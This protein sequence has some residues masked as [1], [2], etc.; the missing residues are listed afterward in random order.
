MLN[1]KMDASLKQ[2]QLAGRL[3]PPLKCK[4]W[5]GVAKKVRERL[6]I[7]E[8]KSEISTLYYL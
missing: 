4:W 5:F 1:R 6:I 8:G 7:Q 2:F 3:L